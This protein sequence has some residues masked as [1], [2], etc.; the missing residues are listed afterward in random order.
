MSQHGGI[1]EFIKAA[2][3][4]GWQTPA[5]TMPARAHCL[6]LAQADLHG[7]TEVEKNLA[8]L[9]SENTS[10]DIKD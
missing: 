6:D 7:Q 5:I 3:T 9:C 10:P 2:S 1:T 4:S 8:W